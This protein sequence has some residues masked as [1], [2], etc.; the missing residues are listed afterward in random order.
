ME[1]M[2]QTDE[3]WAAWE[4]V[5]IGRSQIR[6]AGMGAVPTGFDMTALLR[7]SEALGH[8]QGFTLTAFLSA[9]ED[10]MIVGLNERMREIGADDDADE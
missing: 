9:L 5:M 8:P 7:I 2:P 10:G 4:T 1:H 3:G 6:T